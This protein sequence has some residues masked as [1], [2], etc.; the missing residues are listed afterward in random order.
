MADNASPKDNDIDFSIVYSSVNGFFGVEHKG[1]EQQALDHIADNP[2]P[3]NP[4]TS[5]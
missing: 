3:K 4:L 5:L 1:T 2:A